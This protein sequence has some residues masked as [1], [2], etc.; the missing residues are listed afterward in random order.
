MAPHLL[1]LLT[2]LAAAPLLGTSETPDWIDA[3]PA[4]L[5]EQ[6]RAT[7]SEPTLRLQPLSETF[8][9][10]IRLYEVLLVRPDAV[11]RLWQALGY[12][13]TDVRRDET[14]WYH[15]RDRFGN[16]G[17]WT[18]VYRGKTL[19]V[20]YGE[21][22]ASLAPGLTVPF[23]VVVLWRYYDTAVG[24][25][26]FV[27]HTVEASF[28]LM[29]PA[30]HTIVRSIRLFAEPPARRKLVEGMLSLSI[31]V[32][33]AATQPARFAAWTERAGIRLVGFDPPVKPDTAEGASN[34]AVP[35]T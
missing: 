14:G 12:E 25:R 1:T 21:G 3:I 26:T 4:D 23:Q 20:A 11:T 27:T 13:D 16:A 28:R 19:T 33:M 31:P 5:R 30:Q 17:K 32:R 6:V 22:I 10:D 9:G 7:L 29:N 34:G 8:P 24:G 2:L 15:A 18:Y 35:S